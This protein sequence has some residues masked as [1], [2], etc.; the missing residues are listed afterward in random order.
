[1]WR[2]FF[3]LH[4]AREYTEVGPKPISYTELRNWKEL[5]GLNIS[6][7]DVALIKAMDNAF[8]HTYAQEQEYN[9]QRKKEEDDYYDKK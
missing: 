4:H 9:R 7:D 6:P 1:M 2:W 5:R 3:E 8:I